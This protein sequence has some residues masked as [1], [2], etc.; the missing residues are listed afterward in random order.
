M[1]TNDL[2]WRSTKEKVISFEK[3]I[4]SYT[5]KAICELFGA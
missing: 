4:L 2:A 1:C 5:I 3:Y